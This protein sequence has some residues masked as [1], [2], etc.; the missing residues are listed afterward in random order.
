[1]HAW[2]SD[3]LIAKS[4]EAASERAVEIFVCTGL[5]ATTIRGIF[6]VAVPGGSTPRRMFELLASSDL[7][8]L[9][10]WART[11]IFFTDERYVPQDH[12]DSNY[13][14]AHELLF[15]RVPIPP[16]NVH[17]F[18]TELPPDEAAAAYEED[19]R[20]TLGPEPVFD[21]LILGMGADFHTASLFPN[22]PVLSSPDDKLAAACHV[23]QLGVTRLTL[24]PRVLCNAAETVVIV[25]G[26]HKAPTLR[27]VFE[28]E[29]DP[30]AR[31]IQI[32]KP[33][34]GRMLWIVDETA[35][36]EL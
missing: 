28:S 5:K 16:A 36:S 33:T 21:M 29:P 27:E 19:L 24:T 2:P 10:P 26:A 15:S 34:H 12:P 4:A 9:I 18:K 32:I 23:E 1:M 25:M 13:R 6:T 14:Q 11:H 8:A 35:A 20:K 22:A 30:L 31:P 7:S 3:V 17:R